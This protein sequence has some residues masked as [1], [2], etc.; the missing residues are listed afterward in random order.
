M[1]SILFSPGAAAIIAA[2]SA[3]PALADSG[4]AHG[5]GVMWGM[6]GMGIVWILI[7]I[8]LV[9]GILALIKYLR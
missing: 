8:A 7:L 5:T 4:E 1:K 6:G 9:L 3:A 2:G